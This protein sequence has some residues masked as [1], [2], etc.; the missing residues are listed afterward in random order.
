[1]PTG[2]VLVGQKTNKQTK[3]II[4]KGVYCLYLKEIKLEIRFAACGNED[5]A[6]KCTEIQ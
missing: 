3:I 5:G 6:F 1:V 4:G 2:F